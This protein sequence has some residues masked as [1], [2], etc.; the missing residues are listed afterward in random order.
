MDVLISGLCCGFVS[1]VIQCP[2]ELIKI[3][4]QLG[5][6]TS[7]LSGMTQILR[8]EGITSMF[9]GMSATIGRE[10]PA[11]GCYFYSQKLTEDMLISAH[12]NRYASSFVAGGF[13]GALSWIISY[14]MDVI[15]TDIQMTST[16][17]RPFRVSIY[18]VFRRLVST[19][20]VLFL[21]RGLGTT[22][23]RS[24]PVNAVVFPTHKFCSEML[25]DKLNIS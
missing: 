20:G 6:A 9:R 15:K 17:P 18:S 5:Q 16:G 10:V 7:C 21:Y 19:N 14:P 13:A 3:R 11:F 8:S 1:S 4:L 12:W 2:T 25:R 23:A 22:I 24:V